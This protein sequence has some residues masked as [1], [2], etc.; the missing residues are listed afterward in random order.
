MSF[1]SNLFGRKTTETKEKVGGMEDFMTLIRVYYQASIANQV[2]ITNLAALPDLRVFKQTLKVPTLNNRLGLGEKKRCG[3][4]LT[5]MYGVSEEFC[6]EIDAS[7]K[8]RVHKLQDVQPYLLQFQSFT[9][10]L[11]MLMGNL[12]QWKFRLPSFM[13]SVLRSMT[14][15]TV[16]DILTKNEWKDDNVR[17]SCATVRKMQQALGY[18]ESWMTEFTQTVVMLAKKEKRP[19]VDDK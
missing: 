9:Q 14:E 15:K 19:N 1:F 4:M 12:M 3:K 13:R 16:H 5:E 11:M 8:K 6:K 2:G 18:S 7:I 10:E 17:R